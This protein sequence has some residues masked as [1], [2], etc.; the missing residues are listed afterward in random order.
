MKRFDGRCAPTPRGGG[1]GEVGGGGPG[2]AH[3][4]GVKDFKADSD[5]E[6]SGAIS[7]LA[8]YNY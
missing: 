3:A 6:V 2:R 5:G 4:E 8:S 7:P 1:G